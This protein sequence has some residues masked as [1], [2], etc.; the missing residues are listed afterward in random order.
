MGKSG[1]SKHHSIRSSQEGRGR[2]LMTRYEPPLSRHFGKV[3]GLAG[4]S[5]ARSTFIG[6]E[7]MP[8]RPSRRIVVGCFQEF[9]PT[10]EFSE[11]RCLFFPLSRLSASLLASR[12]EATPAPCPPRMTL[13]ASSPRALEPRRLP[14]CAVRSD[15]VS[16]WPSDHFP[17]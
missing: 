15:V 9:A 16:P 5:E 17:I 11:A 1:H 7:K 3:R 14:R 12:Y 6:G 10:C 4:V 2:G 13:R 8:G